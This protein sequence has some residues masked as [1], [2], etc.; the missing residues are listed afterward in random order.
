[1]SKKIILITKEIVVAII[2][3]AIGIPVFNYLR[4]NVDQDCT[5]EVE[6]YLEELAINPATIMSDYL[7]FDYDGFYVIGPYTSSETKKDIIGKSVYNYKSFQMYLFDEILFDGTSLHDELQELYYIKDSNVVAVA[8][9][10]RSNGDFL[11]NA[12]SYINADTGVILNANREVIMEKRDST[13]L[14]FI[15]CI[16]NT[17]LN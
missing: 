7:T 5:G 13:Q 17:R 9:L 10:D 8:T 2:V 11:R 15:E 1:M 14:P 12:G 6:D 16:V 4:F 3:I